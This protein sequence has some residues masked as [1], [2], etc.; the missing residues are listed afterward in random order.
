MHTKNDTNVLTNSKS[1]SQE[2]QNISQCQQ[3]GI[4]E[5]QDPKEEKHYSLQ[6]KY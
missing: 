1:Q 2:E 6:I 3:G 4:K 5:K